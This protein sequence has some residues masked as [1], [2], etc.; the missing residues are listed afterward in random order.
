MTV[1]LD[2]ITIEGFPTIIEVD[3]D[4]YDSFALYNVYKHTLTNREDKKKIQPKIFW[5]LNWMS[6]ISLSVSFFGF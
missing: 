4:V 2:K 3:R 1:H 6:C 5:F